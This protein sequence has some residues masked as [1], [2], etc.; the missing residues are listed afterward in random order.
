MDAPNII[1]NIIA[2][3]IAFGVG[4]IVRILK[5]PSPAPMTLFGCLLVLCM[6]VGYMTLNNLLK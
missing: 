5:V 2:C 3:L 1:R 6:T 4:A